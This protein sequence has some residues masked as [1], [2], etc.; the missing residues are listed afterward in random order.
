LKEGQEAA[1]KKRW[2]FID[3]SPL[4][5]NWQSKMKRLLDMSLVQKVY[6][7]D[8]C[9]VRQGRPVTGLHFIIRGHALVTV[10]AKLH[11]KQYPRLFDKRMEISAEINRLVR[12]SLIKLTMKIN[13]IFVNK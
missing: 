7:F 8:C 3:S 12:L 2:A 6:P 11:P 10:N 1:R 13:F 9:I 5:S 4:F